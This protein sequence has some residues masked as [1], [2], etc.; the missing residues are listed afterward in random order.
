MSK[1]LTPNPN[2]ISE[3]LGKWEQ[4]ENYRLQ[5]ASLGLL[6]HSLCPRTRKIE[7]VLLKVS[8]LNDFYSTHVFDTYSL[9]KH[10]LQK[11]ID[12]RLETHDYSLVNEIAKIS[13]KGKLKNFYSF[14]SKYCSHH[15]PD[16]YPIFDSFVEK[17]LLYYK[18]SDSFNVFNKSD[19]KNYGHFIEIIKSFQ[20]LYK[21]EKYSLRA[22]P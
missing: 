7:H 6:F 16:S 12:A 13:I 10:I 3:Y 8:A 21:L 18:S 1:P 4:L 17:M 14:A 9:A 2:L 20:R 22:C 19:L 5:E 11:D 15:K